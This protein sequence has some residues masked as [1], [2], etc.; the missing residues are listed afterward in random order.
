MHD[1][2]SG[3]DLESLRVTADFALDGVLPGRS[4]EDRFKPRS[5]GVWEWKLAEPLRQKGKLVV[6]V[7]DRQGNITRVECELAKNC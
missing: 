6:T 3:L 4:L 7:K 1:Y 5:P 2:Y